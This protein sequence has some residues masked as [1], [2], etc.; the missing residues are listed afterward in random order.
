MPL[1]KARAM[2]RASYMGKKRGRKSKSLTPIP[3]QDIDIPLL[4]GGALVVGDKTLSPL[5]GGLNANKSSLE[6]STDT[7]SNDDA[8]IGENTVA[9]ESN[10]EMI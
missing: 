5:T 1:L 7:Q 10:D 2:E 4:V 9:R 3:G 6:Q 8:T